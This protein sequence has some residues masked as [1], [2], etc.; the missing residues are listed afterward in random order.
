MLKT[1][2]MGVWETEGVRQK[3]NGGRFIPQRDYFLKQGS[4]GFF[5][6]TNRNYPRLC[7]LPDH[8]SKCLICSMD[9]Q[10]A[11]GHGSKLIKLYLYTYE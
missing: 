4:A 3:R 8:F 9:N 1:A 6:D 11:N 2:E 7:G 5:K 10:Q